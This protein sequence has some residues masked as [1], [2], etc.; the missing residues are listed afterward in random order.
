[1]KVPLVQRLNRLKLKHKFVLAILVNIVLV[2]A[3]FALVIHSFQEKKLFQ[4]AEE[5][6]LS[7]A[8]SMA[9]DATEGLLLRDLQHLDVI[10]N[11]AQEAIWARYALILDAEGTIVAHTDRS[12]LGGRLEP[13]VVR[14]VKVNEV[15]RSGQTL[16]EEEF[17]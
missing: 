1:M 5:K 8:R 12:R 15:S 14:E 2:L 3:C 11:S 6:N 10:V 17:F 4:N 16:K 7:L 13:P 9:G